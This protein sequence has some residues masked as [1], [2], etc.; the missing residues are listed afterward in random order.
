MFLFLVHHAD[1]LPPHVDHL[2][3]LS[4]IGLAQAE[5]V[6]RAIADHGG[7]PAQIWHSGKLRARQTAEH[8]WQVCNPLAN[9]AAA[10]GIQPGD[11]PEWIRDVLQGDERDIMLVG[12]MPHLGKLL[13]LLVRRER[14][15]APAFPAHGLVALQHGG[16]GWT[17][18]W[19]LEDGK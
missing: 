16:D 17:E 19:R 11:P 7:K 10:R 14:A 12:H 2:R 6:A 15:D 1:A 4:S 9:F 13:D 8:F 3:P 5:R 18:A